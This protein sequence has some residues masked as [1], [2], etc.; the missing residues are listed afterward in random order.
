MHKLWNAEKKSDPALGW[1]EENS[2]CVYQEAFRNLDRALS[3]FI[4][5]RKG[6]Q[7]GKRLG[8]P[9]F[10]RRGRCRDSFRLAAEPMRCTGTTVTLPRL[11]TIR[12]HES[13]RKLTRRL[14]AGTARILSA[15]VSRSAQRWLVMFT[16]EIDRTVPQHHARPGSA[17]GID[18]GV[19]TLLT[20]VDDGG[21][22][23][24]VEGAKPLRVS[25]QK[26][27]RACRAHSRK[28]PGSANRRKSAARLARIHARIAN[29]RTDILHKATSALAVR[30]QTVIVEDLNVA[31]MTR[32][33]RLA[34]SIADQGFGRARPM[35]AYKTTWNG[36]TLIVGNRW[37]PTSKTC[38]GCGHVKA[39]LALSERT[40]RCARCGLVL[41]RDINAARN[42]LDLAASG[43]RG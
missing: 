20:G 24:I 30:Y 31:G 2:K 5:S 38:S 18:L 43:R 35:L 32:N 4:K 22:V 10:K 41:D 16:V 15:T 3:A 25:L 39:K 34:R 42:L 19:K 27:R 36:G 29:I 26:L 12:T 23:L 33:R 8:F 37:L 11:G 9:R 21:N 40:Y 6:E 14:K 28:S 13:T 1:W 7:K 17:I